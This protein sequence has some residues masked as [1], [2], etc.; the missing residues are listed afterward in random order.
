MFRKRR[1]GVF[2]VVLYVFHGSQA[3]SDSLFFIVMESL[4][5]DDR[6]NSGTALE[7]LF[8]LTSANI[9]VEH[10]VISIRSSRCLCLFNKRVQHSTQ[11]CLFS[12]F[13][14]SLP[15]EPNSTLFINDIK[16]VFV[17]A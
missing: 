8:R 15:L 7:Y 11:S 4:R 12:Y 17:Y 1:Q 6:G 3:S 10:Q 14:L 5:H 13:S 2:V 16:N 9:G